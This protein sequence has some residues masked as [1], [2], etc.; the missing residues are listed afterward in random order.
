MPS[1]LIEQYEVEISDMLHRGMSQAEIVREFKSRGVN[2][3]ASSLS[4]FARGMQSADAITAES[5]DIG[6]WFDAVMHLQRATTEE[7]IGRMADITEGLQQLKREGDERFEAAKAL[8]DKPS[9]KHDGDA[10][11]LSARVE[12]A[13]QRID[14]L[15]SRTAG[16]GLRWVWV[17]AFLWASGV[18]ALAL[19]GVMAYL[20]G[21]WP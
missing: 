9:A 10:G 21:G 5:D 6:P 12:E 7:L 18:W 1:Y 3:P 20:S 15:A 11:V 16:A 4:D 19:L 2:L 8:I 14:A 13:I 17:K